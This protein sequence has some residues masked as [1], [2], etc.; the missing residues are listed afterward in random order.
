MNHLAKEKSPY[1][2][3]HAS[4]PV[5][6]YPWGEEAFELARKE[7]KPIFLSIGYATCHWCH[8]MEKES[9]ENSDVAKTMNETFINVKVD[10]E[11]LPQVDNFYMEFAQAMMSTPGGWP[12]NVLLTP[13]LKPFFA[14]TYLPP[15]ERKGIMGLIEFCGQIN[16]LWH[17]EEKN[18]LMDQAD[19]LLEIMEHSF[20][21]KGEELPDEIQIFNA[22][23][24]LFSVADEN[25]GGIKGEPKFPLGYQAEFLLQY[26]KAKKES[27][28]L[29]FVEVTLDN[30]YKGGI[31]DHLGG[32]FS[33][34]CTDE[35]WQIPH[36]EKML[37]DNAILAKTYFQ[38]W[39][40][41]KKESYKKVCDETIAYVL[42]EMTHPE[43]G[44]YSAEDAD[45]DGHEGLFY[46]WDYNEIQEIL[47]ED[48]EKFCNAFGVTKEG[49]FEGRNVLHLENSDE[50]LENCKKALF[51]RRSKR[52]H[53]FKDD[54]ILSSW[55]GLMI[56]ALACVGYTDAAVKAADFIYKNLWKEGRLL[57]RFREGDSRFRAG[58]DEYAFM[59][60]GLLSLYEA[61]MGDRFFQ[62]ALEMT[63][64]LE[65]EFKAEGGAF[66]QTDSQD[67]LLFRKCDFYDGAEP[68]GNGVHLENLLRLYQATADEHFLNQ[69]ED[70]LKAAEEFMETFPPGTSYHYM[71]LQR[72]YDTDAPT[73]AIAL[74]ESRTLEK[75]IKEMLSTRF[76]PHAFI[77]WNPPDKKPIDGQT[78]VY[79]CTQG[80][81]NDPLIKKEDI[82]QAIS[83]L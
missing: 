17:S 49:N 69:A 23:Q 77:R 20:Q 19:Q 25:Y 1:L 51:E 74:D 11:E 37:Y 63:K 41:T 44:F 81:C 75:E 33:R 82:V 16:S 24:S 34:Y 54:K 30:M 36:F 26:A 46:T 55:N 52:N 68:S 29:Y 56:D 70:I 78:T 8:V 27:R 67:T 15:R 76:C 21:T 53:P 2:L 28:A 35:K 32:G 6:W 45:S 13:D 73:I 58:L 65:S 50:G 38:S 48:T 60:K 80:V 59:I 79:F 83:K 4:N 10:R 18:N 71:G 66:Y 47:K 61:G 14:V 31:Y 7:D 22:A 72:Y 43:G 3:Q 39:K 12:L 40:Y 64:I 57:R 9:F 62:W 5:D 42:R